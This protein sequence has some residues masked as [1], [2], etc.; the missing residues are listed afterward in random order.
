L[1]GTRTQRDFSPTP[2]FV[3]NKCKR[4]HLGEMSVE[5]QIFPTVQHC[6]LAKRALSIVSGVAK[7][8][9]SG[10]EDMDVQMIS[11]KTTTKM[12]EW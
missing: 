8:H 11:Q 4:Q 6:C 2:F 7:F 3:T 10:Q 12:D 1:E 5:E 9:A